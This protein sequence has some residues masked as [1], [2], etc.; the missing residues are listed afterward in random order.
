MKSK[1]KMSMRILATIKKCLILVIIQLRQ[2]TTMI[3]TISLWRNEA[4][5]LCCQ[6]WRFCQIEDKDVFIVGR[7]ESWG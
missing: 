3:Q 5:S 7:Q 2:N 4:W 6:D 1:L